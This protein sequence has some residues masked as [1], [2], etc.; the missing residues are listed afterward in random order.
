[1]AER[2]ETV[3][4]IVAKYAVVSNPVKAKFTSGLAR[5]SLF[6]QLLEYGFLGGQPCLGPFLLH[7]YSLYRMRD[8]LGG[9]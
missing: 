7:S 1:M 5:F 9:L 4:E 6:S 2:L 3:D 8:C